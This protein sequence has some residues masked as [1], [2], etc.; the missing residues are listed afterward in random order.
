MSAT[1]NKLGRSLTNFLFKSKTGKQN[2]NFGNNG[3][4][5]RDHM[6]WIYSVDQSNVDRHYLGRSTEFGH[7]MDQLSR[8]LDRSIE[9]V[10]QLR[11]G[12]IELVC[13]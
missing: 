4:I 12:T 13:E 11:K 6:W 1:K 5:E 8:S 7:L 2:F 3:Q 10:I 9:L